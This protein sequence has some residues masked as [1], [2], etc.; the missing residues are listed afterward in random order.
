MPSFNI[1]NLHLNNTN[2][3]LLSLHLVP[4]TIAQKMNWLD[5]KEVK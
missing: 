2:A 3:M 5:S 1:D 4:T